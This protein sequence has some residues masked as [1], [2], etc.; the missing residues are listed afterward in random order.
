MPIFANQNR[1]QLRQEGDHWVLEKTADA[2]SA[3]T[4]IADAIPPLQREI[5][6]L[7]HDEKAERDK[8]TEVNALIALKLAEM[9]RTVKVASAEDFDRA[10]AIVEGDEGRQLS[11]KLHTAFANLNTIVNTQMAQRSR[12]WEDSVQASRSGILTAVGLATARPGGSA[13]APAG[14][15][16]AGDAGVGLVAQ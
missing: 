5:L 13:P 1:E 8:L 16:R 6:D 9:E 4:L 7:T 15:R 12:E 3:A 14:R 11:D 2:I 10:L